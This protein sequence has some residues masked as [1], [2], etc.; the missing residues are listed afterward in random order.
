MRL[1]GKWR[2][3]HVLY[4]CYALCSRKA[5]D[6]WVASGEPSSNQ[7]TPWM[8]DLSMLYN[9]A[10]SV[11]RKPWLVDC[12]FSAVV[13]GYGMRVVLKNKL[14][15]FYSPINLMAYFPPILLNVPHTIIVKFQHVSHIF[16]ILEQHRY[17]NTIQGRKCLWPLFVL[18]CLL[19]HVVLH[20]VIHSKQF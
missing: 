8:S 3:A 14:K 5:H 10:H 18:L 17:K 19:L 4:F 16:L 15:D 9:L 13:V 2:Q 6:K 1:T 20:R 7:T 11:H 12:L